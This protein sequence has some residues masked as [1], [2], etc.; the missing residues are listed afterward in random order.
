MALTFDAGVVVGLG[1]SATIAIGAPLAL[2]FVLAKRFDAPLAAFGWGALTF[3]VSQFVLRLPWQIPLNAYLVKHYGQDQAVMVAWLAVSALTAGIFEEGGR[4]LAYRYV[5]KPRT[6]IGGV[7]LGVGHGGIESI[8]LIGL[9]IASSLV[10][11]VALANGLTLGF[12]PEVLTK[13][14]AQFAKLDFGT[15]LLGGVE[16]IAAL[17]LHTG[18]SLLVLEFARGR[19]VKW[20]LLSIATHASLNGLVM[21]LVKLTGPWPAELA[22]V[23]LSATVLGLA[24]RHSSKQELQRR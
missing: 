18:C 13:I 12:A 14:D 4:A 22:L 1:I 8:V 21:A 17:M 24:L 16:R 5:W 19:G 20:L 3:V 2:M 15:S 11:Y 10:I 6:T 7:A 9:S 23:A